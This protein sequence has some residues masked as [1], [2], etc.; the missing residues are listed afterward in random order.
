M[1]FSRLGEAIGWSTNTVVNY[2]VI[3]QLADW[4]SKPFPPAALLRRHAKTVK[5]SFSN[6]KID[7]FI[8][9]KTFPNPEGHQNCITALVQKLQPF[10]WRVDFAYWWSCFRKSLRL[11]PAQQACFISPWLGRGA[12][13]TINCTADKLFDKNHN[14][15]LNFFTKKHYLWAPMS[16]IHNWSPEGVTLTMLFFCLIT[17]HW[18]ALNKQRNASLSFSELLGLSP[19]VRPPR[20]LY[21]PLHTSH[22]NVHTVKLSRDRQFYHKFGIVSSW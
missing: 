20:F 14:K 19:W 9:I 8:V 2:N 4:V 18:E 15:K 7:Y 13:S 22:Y 11:Q 1:V 5:D 3:N 10:H 16:N 21:S 17:L 12:K 6:Y